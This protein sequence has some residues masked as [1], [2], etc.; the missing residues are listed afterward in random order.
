MKTFVRIIK[1]F[2][3]PIRILYNLI[4]GSPA[5]T[6]IG[7]A[8]YTRGEYQKLLD[9]A[10]DDLDA[11]VATYDAWKMNADNRVEEMKDKGWMV[12]KVK[13]RMD[14]LNAWL[15]KYFLMNISGNRENM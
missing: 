8:W 10:E 7:Y 15:K 13:I 14:E 5:R 9:S 1:I 6:I 11:L 12:F 2:F 4:Y 3:L